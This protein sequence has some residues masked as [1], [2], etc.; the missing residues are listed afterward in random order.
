[1]SCYNDSTDR[2][3]GCTDASGDRVRPPAD[4][5]PMGGGVRRGTTVRSMN[6]PTMKLV[7]TLKEGGEDRAVSPVL[8]V[9]L[10]IAITVILAGVVGF[11]VLGVDTG[12]P[13]T[14]SAQLQFEQSST[15]PFTVNMT[16]E[17]GDR[18]E[19][20]NVEVVV[21]GDATAEDP[22]NWTADNMTAGNTET[23]ATNAESDD[24]I[25]IVWNDP[26]SDKTSLLGEYTVE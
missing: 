23:V 3:E 19:A 13:D 12:G 24:V 4:R 10:L 25:R 20:D 1:M 5:Y 15:S 9:A 2:G 11:I 14:P 16:H 21:D 26:N 6:D 18:I 17:G 7:E 8:G 22:A